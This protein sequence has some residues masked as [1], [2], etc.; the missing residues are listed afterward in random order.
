MQKRGIQSAQRR[1]R[2]S[3]VPVPTGEP[4]HL[5]PQTRDITRIFAD[6]K[7]L[8][9]VLDDSFQEQRLGIPG[10][11]INVAAMGMHANQRC[12]AFR[13]EPASVGLTDKDS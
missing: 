5:V 13:A 4:V 6:E 10:T 12:E 1:H 7:G 8:E 2:D 9:I 3:L 11:I